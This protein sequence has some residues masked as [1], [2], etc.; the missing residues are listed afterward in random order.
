MRLYFPF[1]ILVLFLGLMA[2]G[3]QAL[4]TEAE[5][6]QR[7][8]LIAEGSAVIEATLSS[9][10]ENLQKAL[11]EGGPAQALSYCQTAAL[12]LTAEIAKK[13]KVLGLKRATD[14]PRNPLNLANSEE[15]ARL[16]TYAKQMAKGEKLSPILE[17]NA[18]GV[19]HLSKPIII[20]EHCLKCHGKEGQELSAEQKKIILQYYPQDQAQGYAKGELRGLWSVLLAEK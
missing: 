1:T 5:Q 8:V 6:A 18:Q 4:P 11:K 12:P 13:Y 16:D 14:K 3:E 10:N 7:K 9:L 2:C 20:A 15:Q 19:W 17:K